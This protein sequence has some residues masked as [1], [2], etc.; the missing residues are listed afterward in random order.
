[1]RG[2]M[3]CALSGTVAAGCVTL[4]VVGCQM[5]VAV[6]VSVCGAWGAGHL[7]A[8]LSARLVAAGCGRLVH[9]PERLGRL[10][11]FPQETPAAVLV[12]AAHSAQEPQGLRALAQASHIQNNVDSPLQEPKRMAALCV[13]TSSCLARRD[14]LV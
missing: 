7:V 9:V 6:C 8:L 5:Q 14:A 13:Y 10:A 2:E 4:P 12:H 1:M 3:N 11:R